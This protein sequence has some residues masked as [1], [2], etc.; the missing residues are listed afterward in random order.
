MMTQ[1][2]VALA[3]LDRCQQ[4]MLRLWET[5][6]RLETPSAVPEAVDKLAGHLDTY[7]NALGMET[8]K[9]RPEGAGTCLAAWT[10]ERELAPVLLL[11]HMDTVHPVG[12]FPGGAWTVKD[13]GCVYGPGVHD[14]KGGLVIA[15]YVIRALQYAG[16]DRRQL[17][18]ALAS[19]EETAH[20]R[21]QRKVVDYLQKTAQGCCA[22]FTFES[23]LMSGDVVTRRKGGGIMK[24]TVEGI[25]SHAGTAPEKGASAVLEAAKKIVAIHALSDPA[26]VTYNCGIIHGGTSANVVPD[27]CE[28]SVA[29][30]FH[31]NQDCEEAMEQLRTIC[32]TVETPGTHCSLGPLVGFPAMEETPGTAAL[33]DIYRGA[34][35]A[36]GLGSPGT[37]YSA[38]CSDSAYTTALGIPTL[39]AVGVLGEGQHSVHEHAR[40][41]SLLTQAKRLTAA[42]LAL[43]DS[44]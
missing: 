3:Y 42:I 25:A 41:G 13:D 17:K 22:A 15:L 43:P 29:I 26:H 35:E 2:D 30:R 38:D 7:C 5:V 24:L 19:D 39:C 34:S 9:F 40:I 4:E 16:Y 20:T 14:C 31:T 33:F 6:V 23:G 11:G 36:L 27:H 1:L 12:S 37:V 21:S 28:V 10:A 18:L 8:E 32:G 44:F